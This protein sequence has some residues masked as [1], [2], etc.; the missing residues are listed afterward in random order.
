MLLVFTEMKDAALTFTF[1]DYWK[2][3]VNAKYFVVGY[4]IA[5]HNKR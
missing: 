4:H 2:S 1:Q 3:I 5:A